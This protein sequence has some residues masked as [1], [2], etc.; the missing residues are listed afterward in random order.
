LAADDDAGAPELDGEGLGGDEA[1]G[2]A[3]LH[4]LGRHAD[5]QHRLAE[6]GRADEGRRAGLRDEGR[7]EGAQHDL[8][9][10]V[11]AEAAVE[12]CA[13]RGKGAGGVAQA[14]SRRRRPVAAAVRAASASSRSP[15]RKS[16]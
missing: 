5:R 7:V 14:A 15:W 6:A 9:L 10:A 2:V 1:G 8:A 13:G 4:L 3:A 16:A 11:G 12:L